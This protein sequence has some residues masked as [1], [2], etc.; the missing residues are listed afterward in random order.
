MT[1]CDS[2]M[3]LMR[4]LVPAVPS[5]AEAVP[6]PAPHTIAVATRPTKATEAPRLHA[7]RRALIPLPQVG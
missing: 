1:Y 7:T 2:G 6:A 3:L 5:P 4:L